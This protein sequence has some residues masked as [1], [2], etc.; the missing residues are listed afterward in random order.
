MGVLSGSRVRPSVGAGAMTK[1]GGEQT[2]DGLKASETNGGGFKMDIIAESDYIDHTRQPEEQSAGKYGDTRTVLWDGSSWGI[3]PEA[4]W[5]NDTDMTFYAY[6]KVTA[7]TCQ[8][9]PPGV[10]DP[11]LS[12][13][14]PKTSVVP[15]GQT[16]VLMAINQKKHLSTA[17]PCDDNIS[18]AFYHAMSKISFES[19]SVPSGIT[20]KEIHVRNLKTGGSASSN[21][22]SYSWNETTYSGSSDFSID[23]LSK[24]FLV[25]PQNARD[26][27][28]L[29]DIVLRQTST[30]DEIT[31]SRS[32]ADYDMIQ[33]K[34]YTYR[35]TVNDLQQIDFSV[36]VQDWDDV[37]GGEI[38]PNAP[39]S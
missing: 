38:N 18:L 7:E 30:G 19:A 13:T 16:D 11:G 21:G 31:L 1:S 36:S 2:L 10:G 32:L 20:I 8:M 29:V 12:F 37:N 24:C 5:I 9:V 6:S 3:S 22:T 17:D 15:D 34:V 25:I 26:Y 33:G 28:G 35:V 27:D 39:A 23:D 14:Y 4:F